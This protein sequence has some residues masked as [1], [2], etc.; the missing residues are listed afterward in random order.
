MNNGLE[1]ALAGAGFS[2]TDQQPVAQQQEAQPQAQPEV[3]TQENTS[4][5]N[6]IQ[7]S[8]QPVVSQPSNEEPQVNVEEE[9]LKFLSERLGTEVTDYDALSSALTRTPSEIDERV[10]AI[11][12]FVQKTGR[13]PEDWYKYQQLNPSEMDDLTAVRNHLVVQHG[14]LST[15]EVNLLLNDKYRLDE[16]RYDEDEIN[17]SKLRLKMDAENAR[18]AINELREGYMLPDSQASGPES[19]INEEWI[20]TMTQEVNDFDGLVFELPSGDNFTFGIQDNYRKSLIEKNRNIDSFFSDYVNDNGAWNFE[21]LNAHRAVIDNIDNIVKSVYQQG[22][23][24]GQR[25]VVQNAAN[26][27]NESPRQNP[28]QPTNNLSEQLAKALG[29]GNTLTFNV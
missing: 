27:S 25:K 4:E 16:N 8:A 6:Q 23:S 29:G 10:A 14:N 1:E 3:Q 28:N 11:N 7:E 21:K 12:E 13:S 18:N 19:P 15:E 17:M 22:I 5:P 24:D 2:L 9:V 26:I 20:N